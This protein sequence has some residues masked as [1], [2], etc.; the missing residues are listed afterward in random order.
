MNSFS[1]YLPSSVKNPTGRINKPGDYM[2][3][4][5]KTFD[6]TG[7]WEVALDEISYPN[8][9]CNISHESKNISIEKFSRRPTHKEIFF[10]TSTSFK[11]DLSFYT[12][13]GVVESFIPQKPSTHDGT[14]YEI[15]TKLKQPVWEE[16]NGDWVEAKDGN[17]PS[18]HVP[19]T[20]LFSTIRG[21]VPIN[22]YNTV[23]ELLSI[24][25]DIIS[26]DMGCSSRFNYLPTTNMIQLTL[27]K[28]EQ[29]SLHPSLANMLGFDFSFFHNNFLEKETPM[30]YIGG[31]PPNV[32]LGF[33]HIY[34]Y[35]NIVSPTLVGDTYV[36]ILR[37]VDTDLN[38]EILTK[39]YIF[40]R[41]QYIRVNITNLSV[42]EI[43][44][45]DAYGLPIE[46]NRG[47]ETIVR[48]T[49]RQ[50]DE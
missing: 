21:S 18:V 39:H 40:E 7:R 11:K 5:P 6:L 47:E 3:Y 29:L 33:H 1:M 42:I 50:W 45:C 43:K 13:D 10:S 16:E 44:L 28:M 34:I 15:D 31:H 37:I 8:R 49:F 32:H 30:I 4:L 36:S 41:P 48:L 14:L 38:P 26:I 2:T 46:Y 24:L 35:T 9:W 25:N 27:G 12:E 23:D 17:D 19:Y 22:R 20:P